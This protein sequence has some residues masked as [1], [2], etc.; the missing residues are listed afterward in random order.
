MELSRYQAQRGDRFA[1][2]SIE[3]SLEFVLAQKLAESADE[4][5][6]RLVFAPLNFKAFALIRPLPHALGFR[7]YPVGASRFATQF[8]AQFVGTA[9]H[10]VIVG[11]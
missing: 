5:S 10:M 4:K 9:Q 1:Y 2:T 11:F 3:E 7:R 6:V 8:H